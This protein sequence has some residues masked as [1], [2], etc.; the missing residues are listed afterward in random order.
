M[1]SQTFILLAL[2]VAAG[3]II[4]WGETRIRGKVR[5]VPYIGR[6]QRNTTIAAVAIFAVVLTSSINSFAAERKNSEC[7]RQF[8]SALQYNQDVTAAQRRL[9]D[10]IDR[11]NTQRHAVIDN[12]FVELAK[13][14]D[15]ATF[16]GLVTQY[17]K[18]TA[19]ANSEIERVTREKGL[20]EDTRRPYPAPTCGRA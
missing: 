15:P 19:I 10:E 6:N 20:L 7:Y 8:F 4:D 5:T 13:G 12:V 3:L 2:G 11:Y 1:N 17:N 9:D 14:V 18:E 16:A